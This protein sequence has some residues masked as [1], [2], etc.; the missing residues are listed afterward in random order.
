MRKGLIIGF[1][2]ILLI[3]LALAL[4]SFTRNAENRKNAIPLPSSIS[5][6]PNLA[7]LKLLNS[8]QAIAKIG[9]VELTS[10]DLKDQ[11]KYSTRNVQDY[12]SLSEDDLSVKVQKAFDEMVEE[13][14]LA[15]E[16]AFGGI[17]SALA[18][19][20]RRRELSTKLVQEE[21]SRQPQITDAAERDFY[22]NHGEKF[23]LA[24]SN[25]VREL[26]IPFTTQDDLKLKTGPSYQKTKNLAERIR[27][28]ESLDV[29]ARKYVPQSVEKASGYTFTGAVMDGDD[30]AAVLNLKPGIVAG[31]F[32]IEGGLSIFQGISRIPQRFIPFYKAQPT[33]HQYL[34][35]QRLLQV[36]RKLVEQ[37]SQKILVRKFEPSTGRL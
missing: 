9:S 1:F 12:H 11:L 28:G 24:P 15:Q 23:I 25:Q 32:R 8:P 14:I 18:N 34:E 22:K 36:K 17:S 13:E 19:S 20:Q 37:L 5:Y 30:A 29:L 35:E 7:Y 31:P 16:A 27:S 26:F 33:I 2:G 21:A 10:N 3:G 6:Q 4:F